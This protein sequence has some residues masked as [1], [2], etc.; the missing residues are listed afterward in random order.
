MTLQ[1]IIEEIKFELT[2]GVLELEIS[3]QD[4]GLAI[5]KALRE[6]IRYWDETTLVTIPFSSKIN[7]ANSPLDKEK[8]SA[9]VNIYR[10]T[11][12]G[13]NTGEQTGMSDPL[14]A[15][16]WMIF[17]NGGTM[18]NLNDYVLNYAAWNTLLQIKNTMSTDL[19]FKEDRHNNMLYINAASDTPDKITIEYIP[20]LTTP[21]Q[22]KS[23]YW[24]DILIRLSLAITKII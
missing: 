1:E 21:E 4:I 22:V 5:K 6:L 9:I 18:Y 10:T 3:D 14:Y 19:A 12:Y 24:I 20:K 17:S 15:Q 16:Q 2:G 11:G 7:L 8:V 23:D 13:N